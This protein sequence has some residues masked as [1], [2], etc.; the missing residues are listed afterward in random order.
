MERGPVWLGPVL[1]VVRGS[2]S[3]GGLDMLWLTEYLWRL[4]GTD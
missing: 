3:A 4:A 2:G 1:G